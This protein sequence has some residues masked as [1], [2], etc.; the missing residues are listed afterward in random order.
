MKQASRAEKIRN[1]AI[2]AWWALFFAGVLI[3]TFFMT[4]W[5][6]RAIGHMPPL[7]LVQLIN[8]VLGLVLYL[9]LVL[10][11]TQ[12]PFIRRSRHRQLGAFE[13]IFA[14]MEQ[15]AR[16][17]FQVHLDADFRTNVF[18]NELARS[19]NQMAR[20]LDQMEQLRQEFI[21]NVSH[22]IQSPVTSI[23]GFAR[24]LHDESLSVSDREHYLGVIEAET[25]RLSGMTDNMLKLASLEAEDVQ[26]DRRLYRLD[27][28]LTRL[29]LASEPQWI[30]KSVDMEADL[31]EL[32]IFAGEDLLD[33]VW[34]NLLQN[35]IKFTPAGGR[36]FVQATRE[37]RAIQ[38]RI[39]DTGIG[40]PPEARSHI[41]ERFYKVDQ[42]RSSPG[43]GLG[44]AIAK[45]IV[46]LHQGHIGIEGEL[47]AGTTIIVSL[48]Q[49]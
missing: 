24:L 38:C 27:R 35:S 21:A 47:G 42:S 30:A 10:A 12:L 18:A 29:I 32:E 48:P 7:F 5:L 34:T 37:G 20:E 19:V 49:A 39:T 15:I 1:T 44:L 45:R 40:I 4:A 41:F 23:R 36:V 31:E 25:G 14:A 16:G 2:V 22:E 46:D 17:D 13:P 9:L 28:Q 43:S 6:Y 8:T 33:L 26:R 3:A 11:I